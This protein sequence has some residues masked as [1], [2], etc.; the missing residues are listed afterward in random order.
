MPAALNALLKSQAHLVAPV[1]DPD[2][3]AV[4]GL[5]SGNDD[6]LGVRKAQ[7]VPRHIL[8]RADPYE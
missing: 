2:V 1:D 4:R 8:N 7:T 3:L 5:R 6:A